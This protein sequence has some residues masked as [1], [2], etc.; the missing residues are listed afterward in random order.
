[1]R[2]SHARLS[3]RSNAALACL[4][5]AAVAGVLLWAAAGAR[6]AEV[7]YWN[8][9]QSE[10]QSLGSSNI[11][12]SGGGPLNLAG[13]T[14]DNPE[15]M[16]IDTLGNRIYVANTGETGKTP[17]PGSISFVN[18][19]GSGGGT[20]SP[21][22]V[23]IQ[24]PEGIALDPVSRTLYWINTEPTESIAWAKLD[25][26]AGGLLSTTGAKLEG[27]YRLTIDTAAGRVYWGDTSLAAA[28]ISFA[29]LNNSGG[30]NLSIAGATPPEDISGLAIDPVA[31]R[32]YWG[33]NTK[34]GISYTS[35]SGGSG[36]DVNLTGASF[37]DSY[38]LALDPTLSRLYW[39]NYEVKS[40]T[41]AFGFVGLGGGGGAISIATAPLEGPQD[42]MIL[43]SPT[44]A[45][46]PALTRD[47][48]AKSKLTCSQGSWGADFP[49]SFVYQAPRTFAYQWTR[50]GTPVA[51]ATASAF[52]ATSVGSYAC[53][54]TAA[55][56]AGAGAQTS[57]AVAV[58]A[59]KFK[60]KTKKKATAKAGGTATFKLSAVN[61]GDLEPKIAMV[62][63]KLPKKTK[64]AGLK[65]PKCKPL[66]KANAKGTRSATLKFKLTAN[67]APGTYKVSF[68]VSG[69]AGK[70]VKAKVVVTAG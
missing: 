47:A 22:G 56:Q 52:T 70:P 21:P 5:L 68:K 24:N 69:S 30:G 44:G 14:L 54:V 11:D 12:G 35:L 28:S 33:D 4:A 18:L 39:G 46:V 48:K 49:G 51:G 10:P 3:S 55:N 27:A 66:G 38:G 7:L 50:N 17:R 20:F 36:G 40:P 42:P 25:G 29:N 13:T 15:G 53:V 32:I 1:M 34:E 9:Y 16:A 26:S 67:T 45:G 41:N 2:L 57:A 23:P 65:A 58:K 61:Q 62:C 64:K 59:A 63:A 31:K 19:D 8:N 60:L 37:K 43:K 6:G